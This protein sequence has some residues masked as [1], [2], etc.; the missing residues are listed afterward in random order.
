MASSIKR[1]SAT[2]DMPF[3]FLDL[4][5]DL[6]VMIYRFA[7]TAEIQPI[8]FRNAK[9]AEPGEDRVCE[10]EKYQSPRL[11]V[12]LLATCSLIH[13]EA[14]AE[15]YGENIFAIYVDLYIK[16]EI[17][18]RSTYIDTRLGHWVLEPFSVDA[19]CSSGWLYNSRNPVYHPRR[20]LVRKVEL[21]LPFPYGRS[22]WSDTYPFQSEIV[23]FNP[24]RMEQLQKCTFA[25]DVCHEQWLSARGPGRLFCEN[26][27][28]DGLNI[29]REVAVVQWDFR[30]S[31]R[32]RKDFLERFEYREIV[33][34]FVDGPIKT[35]QSEYWRRHIELEDA[36]SGN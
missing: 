10:N 30:V 21:I 6:R 16:E 19:G 34:N 4:P 18:G 1:Q 27:I 13:Q 35:V 29:A 23:L 5:A 25:F 11:P 15:L 28:L 31:I 14:A 2:R 26:A 20:N 12:A 36:A 32:S 22:F 24:A 17:P 7:L 3:R 33:E 9:K 8:A